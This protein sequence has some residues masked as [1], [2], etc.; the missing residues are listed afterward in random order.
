MFKGSAT[1]THS[2]F[3][4]NEGRVGKKKE[5]KERPTDDRIDKD[6]AK[7][8]KKL[9]TSLL[10][11]IFLSFLLFPHFFLYRFV[12]LIH[13]NFLLSNSKTE[14]SI[15]VGFL[16]QISPPKVNRLVA[17]WCMSNSTGPAGVWWGYQHI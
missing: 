10:T 3:V 5:K 15:I 17:V 12:F 6:L 14:Q 13:S 11:A 7:K 4:P 2:Y 16:G 1:H 9:T 8:F